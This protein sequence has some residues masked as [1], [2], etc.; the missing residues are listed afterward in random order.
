MG[1]GLS[2]AKSLYIKTKM[3]KET[4]KLT[5]VPKLA[6]IK[7]LSRRYNL[8]GVPLVLYQ[9]KRGNTGIAPTIGSNPSFSFSTQSLDS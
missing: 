1:Y 8:M 7:L 9:L 2:V 3:D 5:Y 6:L 4:Y